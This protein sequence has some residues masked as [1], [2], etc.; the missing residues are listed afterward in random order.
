MQSGSYLFI[1]INVCGWVDDNL[2]HVGMFVATVLNIFCFCVVSLLLLN[3]LCLSVCAHCY[4]LQILVTKLT[5]AT[6]CDIFVLNFSILAVQYCQFDTKLSDPNL[7]LFLFF[8]HVFH[9]CF[10]Q[11]ADFFFR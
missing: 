2:F 5:L 6:S 1:G 7:Q 11:R 4:T 8:F 9:V 3:K 10:C